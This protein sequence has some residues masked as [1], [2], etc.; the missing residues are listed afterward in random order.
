MDYSD[1]QTQTITD[2]YF[3]WNTFPHSADLQK[4]KMVFYEYYAI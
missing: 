2:L 4:N 3:F 1:K